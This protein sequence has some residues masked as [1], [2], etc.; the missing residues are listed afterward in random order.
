VGTP[1]ERVLEVLGAPAERQVDGLTY[2]GE[3]ER[4]VFT[5]ANGRIAEIQVVYHAD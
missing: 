3:S 5:T 4:I 2:L 1:A